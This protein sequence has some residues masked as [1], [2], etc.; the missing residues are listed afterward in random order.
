GDVLVFFTDGV[1]EAADDREEEYSRERL[2][3]AAVAGRRLPAARL[4]DSLLGGVREFCGHDEFAD[5]LTLMV[6]KY[7]GT[8]SAY[9]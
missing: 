3:A 7:L 8:G 6:V 1:V 2:A 5:D 4:L 9:G